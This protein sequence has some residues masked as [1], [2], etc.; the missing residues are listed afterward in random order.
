[1]LKAVKVS[2]IAFGAIA[3]SFAA[4]YLTR[5]HYLKSHSSTVGTTWVTAARSC[6][7]G[8]AQQRDLEISSFLSETGNFR[9]AFPKYVTLDDESVRKLTSKEIAITFM[10]EPDCK[11]GI[12]LSGGYIVDKPAE[13]K[14]M[15]LATS[16]PRTCTPDDPFAKYGGHLSH[17][18]FCDVM[19]GQPTKREG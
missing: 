7:L 19:A 13:V 14:A 1:M 10:K 9:A 17:E 5:G 16:D 4:G 11:G 2:V 8:L 12:D 3:A 18:W 6:W 15:Y